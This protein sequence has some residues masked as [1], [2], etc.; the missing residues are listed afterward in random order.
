M[1]VPLAHPGGLPADTSHHDTHPH[2]WRRWLFATNHK[3]IGTMYLLFSFTMFI[4]GGV[5]AMLIRLEL[6]QPGLQFFHPQLFNQFT[7]MH[8]LIMIFGA[9]MPAFVGLANWM[10]PL[11]VGAPDMAFA[12]MNNLSFWL[13]IPAALMLVGSFFM[14]GGAPA[15][16]WTLYAP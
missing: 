7:T 8:G 12:R 4:V 14:P 3:D 16:G 6:F 15:A 1:S 9:I 13:L 5:L 2:G 11:Q 10:V